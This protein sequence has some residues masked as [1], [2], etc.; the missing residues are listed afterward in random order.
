MRTYRQFQTHTLYMLLVIIMACGMMVGCASRKKSTE[1][2]LQQPPIQAP[3]TMI[4]LDNSRLSNALTEGDIPEES[5]DQLPWLPKRPPQGMQFRST[6]ELQTVY[7]EFDKFSLTSQARNTLDSNAAW[8]EN[9]PE[10]SVQLA[11]HCD[12]RGTEEYN[13]VLGEN[14]AISVKKYLVTLGIDSDRLF[15][16]SYGETIPAD[17]DH[18]EDAWA[19]NRRV[20]FKIS[21]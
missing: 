16:I 7:F 2:D 13:Q 17:P 18:N 6:P 21:N 10:V 12:E 5:R 9:H 19:K 1:A 11:G 4:E 15:T 3:P 20:E 14:R 8:L